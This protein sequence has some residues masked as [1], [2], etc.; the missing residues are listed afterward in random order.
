MVHQRHGIAILTPGEYERLLS[1]IDKPSLRLL[2]QVL[3][4]TGMRYEEV[5]RLKQFM[6]PDDYKKYIESVK[7]NAFESGKATR[8]SKDK[9]SA[10]KPVLF[11]DEE[12]IWVKSGKKRAKSPE[13][14]IPLTEQ[15]REAV[16]AYLDDD[17]F[18]YPTPAGMTLNLTKWAIKAGLSPI[19]KEQ[20]REQ[21]GANIGTEQRNIYGMSVKVFRRTWEN[22]LLTICPE[23]G[24]DIMQAQGHDVVTASEHYA[25][26]AFSSHDVEEIRKYVTGWKPN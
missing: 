18:G 24:F 23:R 9:P 26:S 12:Y 8:Y 17:R 7:L 19:H 3:L 22:W 2:V 10:D 1:V 21:Y 16:K 4:L 5:L 13:R 20:R 14:N 11:I 25:G 15:G 6:R